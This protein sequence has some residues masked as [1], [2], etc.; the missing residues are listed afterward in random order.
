[1][2]KKTEKNFLKTNKTMEKKL[3][4]EKYFCNNKKTGK[5]LFHIYDQA[6]RNM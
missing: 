3:K 1:M 5:E 2:K 6:D 4:R